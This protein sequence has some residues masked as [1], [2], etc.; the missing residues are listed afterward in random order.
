MNVWPF[1]RRDRRTYGADAVVTGAGS[2]IGRAFAIELSRR[3]GR[4]VCADIDIGSAQQTSTLITS[5][6]GDAIAIQCDV[7]D[8]R[9]VLDLANVAEGWFGN[10]VSLMINNAGIGTGGTVVGETPLDDWYRTIEVNLW[11]VIHGCH[12]LA[13]RLRERGS[14]G[15]IN[16]ASA[17]SFGAGPRMAAYNVSKAGVLSLSETLA[18]ELSGTG[19]TITVLCPTLVKTNINDNTAITESAAQLAD[20]LMKWIGSSPQSIAQTTLDAHDRGQLHVMPQ[21]DAKVAWQLKRL[22]PGAF[23]RALGVIE[24][25]A[26]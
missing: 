21:L 8:A 14:G 5:K 25:I 20:T 11:G 4:V 7:A 6:G 17:A 19:V 23:T 16:V 13:P 15:I 22:A 26:S 24:R 2:G 12:V 1:A 9:Q 10:S 3:D 18:A